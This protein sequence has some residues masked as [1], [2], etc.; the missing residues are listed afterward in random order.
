MATYS[1]EGIELNP[2]RP[3]SK[4]E[5]TMMDKSVDAIRRLRKDDAIR[6]IEAKAALDIILCAEPAWHVLALHTVDAASNAKDDRT[7]I[8][9]RLRAEGMVI[10]LAEVFEVRYG[11]HSG[12][13]IA[14]SIDDAT[15]SPFREDMPGAF[16]RDMALDVLTR[17]Y[18]KN[19]NAR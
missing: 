7:R 4:S 14:D 2:V 16:N 3:L 13:R 9:M 15:R 19:A 17:A 11:M 5:R 18:S 8:G 10:G 1:Y 6:R 12:E